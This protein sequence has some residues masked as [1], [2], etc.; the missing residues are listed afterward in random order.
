MLTY[1]GYLRDIIANV[2]AS[3]PGARFCFIGG[4]GCLEDDGPDNLNRV[5]SL[6]YVKPL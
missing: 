2:C 5:L 3:A 4:K 1:A 6:Y